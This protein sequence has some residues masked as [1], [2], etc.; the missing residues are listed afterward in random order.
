M[1]VLGVHKELKLHSKVAQA[2]FNQM[3]EKSH[4]NCLTYGNHEDIVECI[5]K[6]GELIRNQAN[7]YLEKNLALANKLQTCLK[8]N[9]DKDTVAWKACVA[10]VRSQIPKLSFK[11]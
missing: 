2:H 8:I 6:G 9:Q 5:Q 11:E 4:A 1:D 7:R 3:M 10:E